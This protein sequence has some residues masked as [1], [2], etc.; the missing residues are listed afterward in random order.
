MFFLMQTREIFSRD[1]LSFIADALFNVVLDV[2]HVRWNE[3]HRKAV[4]VAEVFKV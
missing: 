2:A 3:G 4:T 1:V